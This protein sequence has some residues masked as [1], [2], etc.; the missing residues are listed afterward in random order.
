M[1][2]PQK[3]TAGGT[4]KMTSRMFAKKVSAE[5]S[6]GSNGVYGPV[7][8]VPQYNA[9]IENFRTSHADTVIGCSG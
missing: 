9:P 5:K 1:S 8:I 3:H 4:G 7:I 6:P 2:Q